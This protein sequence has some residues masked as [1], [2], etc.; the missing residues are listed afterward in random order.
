MRRIIVTLAL[1]LF[2]SGVT[3]A[4]APTILVADTGENI[5]VWEGWNV[6][7]KIFLRVDGGSGPD[8]VSLWWITMGI[9]SEP[10][11]V[12]DHAEIDV[13]LPFIYGELRAGSFVRRT[14]L[15]VGDSVN[16]AYSKELCT[17]L[18]ECP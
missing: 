11:Q 1:L 15:A 2:F 4:N 5:T 12:C 3:S 14:A 10:W 18:E 9:N 7:G 17:H 13:A 16:V 6:R 8:C